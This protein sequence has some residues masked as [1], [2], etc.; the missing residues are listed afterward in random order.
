M[1]EEFK[2]KDQLLKERLK[3]TEFYDKSFIKFAS[4]GQLMLHDRETKRN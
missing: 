1:K 3:A 4:E 2:K